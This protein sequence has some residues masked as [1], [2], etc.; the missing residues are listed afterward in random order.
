MNNKLL[1]TMFAVVLTSIGALAFAGTTIIS[2]V[3][4]QE[5][6]ATMAGNMTLGS[7]NM[8]GT[9]MTNGTGNISGVEDPF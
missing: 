1:W 5:D 8:T 4:A 3:M 2:S 6:N 7:G 9:N